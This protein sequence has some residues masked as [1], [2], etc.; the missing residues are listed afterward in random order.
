[1]VTRQMR[2]PMPHDLTSRWSLQR[3]CLITNSQRKGAGRCCYTT[4]DCPYQITQQLGTTTGS[5]TPR[6]KVWRR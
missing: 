6:S 4:L 3:D 1:V 2:L 5:G